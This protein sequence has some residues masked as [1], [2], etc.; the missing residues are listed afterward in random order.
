M[1][2]D[3]IYDLVEAKYAELRALGVLLM[4]WAGLPSSRIIS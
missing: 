3:G 4:R 2:A 1:V